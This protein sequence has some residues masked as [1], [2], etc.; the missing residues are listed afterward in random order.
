MY[1]NTSYYYRMKT[2]AHTLLKDIKANTKSYTDNIT[3]TIRSI[4]EIYDEDILVKNEELIIKIANDYSLDVN[5]L[6]RRYLKK[7]KNANSSDNDTNTSNEF[8][9]E[10]IQYDDV[11]CYNTLY[12]YQLE[13]DVY[14]IEMSNEGKIYDIND[15]IVGIWKDDVV[16]L[17]IVVVE[18]FKKIN[19]KIQKKDKMSES[20]DTLIKSI[21]ISISAN[22]HNIT[23]QLLNKKSIEI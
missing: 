4:R 14:Y 2:R 7:K 21:D 6:K 17:D 22:N 10:N 8:I 20:I 9:Q 11:Q 3:N 19:Q 13:D 23:K 18:Y 5:E 16:E 1:N 15:N 12:R